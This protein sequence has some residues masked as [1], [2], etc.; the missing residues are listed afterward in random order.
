MNL[1]V[2]FFLF[3]SLISYSECSHVI[4]MQWKSQDAVVLTNSTCIIP[5]EHSLYGERLSCNIQELYH[6]KQAPHQVDL[7]YSNDW[8]IDNVQWSQSNYFHW[9]T[10]DMDV[11]KRARFQHEMTLMGSTSGEEII[12]IQMVYLNHTWVQQVTTAI[13]TYSV[14]ETGYEELYVWEQILI[15]VLA[16]VLGVVV[17]M[18]LIYLAFIYKTNRE[19]FWVSWCHCGGKLKSTTSSGATSRRSSTLIKSTNSKKF[20]QT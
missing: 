8:L 6:A 14:N 16:M 2:L 15:I 7:S 4:T 10:L 17:I 18:F 19:P 13:Y 3:I 12:T 5:Y 1:F 11:M 20:I 9:Y